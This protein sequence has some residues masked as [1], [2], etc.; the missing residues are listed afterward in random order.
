V[1]RPATTADLDA[2]LAWRNQP[3]NRSVSRTTHV[4]G[5][6]EHQDWWEQ[7]S[8]DASRIVLV[9]DNGERTCGVVNFFDIDQEMSTASWGFYLD[10]EGLEDS[11]GTLQA[12]FAVMRG[13][14]DYA[15]DELKVDELAAEVQE[16][17]AVVRQMNRRFG[18]AE[19]GPAGE[20]RDG[21]AFLRVVLTR[22]ERERRA[23]RRKEKNG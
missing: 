23:Q 21:P 22:K 11:G 9:F 12:W 7:V 19:T 8:Q 15:F 1:L 3:A 18:F 13:A 5:T 17:N 4:I 14:T 20:D 2:M 10:N 16:D 6:S